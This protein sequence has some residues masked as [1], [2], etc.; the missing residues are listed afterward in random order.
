MRPPLTGAHE[1]RGAIARPATAAAR[2]HAV[3][4][5][6][7]HWAARASLAEFGAIPTDERVVRD[8]NR[9]TG[10]GVTAGLDFGLTMVAELR[11]ANYAQSVQ[12]LCEY[13]PHPPF[14]S[15]SVHTAPPE[16][17]AMMKGMLAG[18]PAQIHAAATAIKT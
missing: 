15:G 13:D 4:A 1:M 7:S 16:V 14:N 17:L 18:F 2:P 3:A 8:R 6:T 12:L 5:A 9:I 10:A 11:D